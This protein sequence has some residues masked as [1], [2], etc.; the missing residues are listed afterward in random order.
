MI[1]GLILLAIAAVYAAGT[2][3]AWKR[4][5]VGRGITTTQAWTFG[6]GLFVLGLA[7]SPW[8]DDLADTYFAAHM[9][10]HM[11]LAMVAPPFLVLGAPQRA[12]AWS[13]RGLA[14]TAP[15]VSRFVH[16]GLRV[17]VPRPSSLLPLFVAIHAAAFWVW[18]IPRFFLAALDHPVLHAIEH[19]CFLLS[20]V[21]MWWIILAPARQARRR[22][23]GAGILALFATMM[24]T[25]ALGALLTLSRHPWY[26]AAPLGVVGS[27]LEDQQLGGLIMWVVGGFLYMIAMSVLFVA[28]MDRPVWANRPRST[29]IGALA[30]M[31]LLCATLNGCQKNDQNIVMPGASVDRGRTALHDMGCGACH[32][33][34]GVEGA[35]GMVGPPLTGVASRSILAGE[36]ANTP[37]NMVHWIRDPQSVEPGTAM[38]NLKVT[39]PMARDM[40]AYLYTLR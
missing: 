12:L 27:P 32:V 23:Y 20:A 33:I 28:W 36:L 31:L 11:L 4:C 16:R 1:P 15:A 35:R 14:G 25:G 26:A 9:V 17:L 22:S 2:R 29:T 38:P 5:G 3:S 39:G 10:E 37:Q 34:G 7:F 6:A 30:G 21:A 19:E 24:Q 8:L 18:H 13:A 40:A